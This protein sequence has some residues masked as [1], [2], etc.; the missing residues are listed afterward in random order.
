VHR[1]PTQPIHPTHPASSPRLESPSHHPHA[2]VCAKAGQGGT[3]LSS[4]P[5][6]PQPLRGV[7]YANRRCPGRLRQRLQEAQPLKRRRP[8]SRRP[9]PRVFTSQKTSVPLQDINGL[10]YRRRPALAASLYVVFNE[11]H[12]STPTKGP[13]ETSYKPK[14][15]RPVVTTKTKT[16]RQE[17]EKNTTK[18]E[19]NT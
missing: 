19:E 17:G 14:P 11:N 3:A 4:R 9:N 6:C 5:S 8:K 16:H 13:L 15:P 1:L 12:L 10:D 2:S 18:N 7:P